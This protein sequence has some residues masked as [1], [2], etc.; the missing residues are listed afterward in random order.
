MQNGSPY[1][2]NYLNKPHAVRSVGG[3]SL[4]YDLNGNMIQKVDDGVT[5][6]IQWNYDNKPTSITKGGAVTT[7][8]Y[9]GNSQRVRK[10]S[11]SGTAL[12]FGALYE[13]RGGVGIIHLFAGSQRVAS[14]IDGGTTQIYHPDH[15]GSTWMVTDLNGAIKEK[16]E[17][18]PFGTYRPSPESFDYDPS[19]PDVFYTFTGQEED[20]EVGLYNYGARLY[21]PVLGRFISPDSL[22]PDHTDP[23]SLNRYS[24]CVNNPLIYI[25][26]TGNQDEYMD[27]TAEYDLLYGMMDFGGYGDLNFNLGFDNSYSGYSS[28]SFN[29][30]T[31]YDS[32]LGSYYLDVPSL[33]F[34]LN[35]PS[36]FGFNNFGLGSNSFSAYNQASLQF[37]LPSNSNGRAAFQFGYTDINVTYQ[38]I[39]VIRGLIGGFVLT[40]GN[41]WGGF[42]GAILGSF[43]VTGGVQID[44]S[45][46]VYPY[47]GPALSFS[48]MG[49]WS[50]AVMKSKQ[51]PTPG[52]N[53]AGQGGLF[54]TAERGYSF[55]KEGYPAGRFAAW[56]FG[57]PLFPNTNINAVYTFGPYRIW[58]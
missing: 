13:K 10:V 29:P 47:I 2:Y 46:N 48:S 35:T 44:T 45:G 30:G 27:S 39:G 19:F 31:N 37:N 11:S 18:Y 1:N 57:M 17:Y 12:Y 22:V 16:N 42:G 23:Q 8:T 32:G 6:T 54:L 5:T 40:G 20:G 53:I 49:G 3:I 50:L 34:G 58:K 14:V 33:S 26:P 41:I 56:G 24:Y 55:G 4:D 7:F 38:P 28:F 15:L 52:W 51:D 36:A 21:D 9:D 43:C 25:D